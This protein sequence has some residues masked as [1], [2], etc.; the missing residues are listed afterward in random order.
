M[1]KRVIAVTGGHGVLGC[2]VVEAAVADGLQVAAVEGGSAAASAG[3]MAG[4]LIEGIDGAAVTAVSDLDRLA[5]PGEHRLSVRR[6]GEAVEI[7]LP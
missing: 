1:A 2:A 6:E 5:A 4:D 7:V 3:L